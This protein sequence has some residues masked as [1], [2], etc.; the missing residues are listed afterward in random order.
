MI[1]AVEVSFYDHAYVKAF[2]RKCT[3]I[4]FKLFKYSVGVLGCQQ[5]DKHLSRK[6]CF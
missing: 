2:N 3:E 4:W 1:G 5:F 6:A